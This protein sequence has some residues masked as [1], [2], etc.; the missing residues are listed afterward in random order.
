LYI[1][2]ISQNNILYQKYWFNN[3]ADRMKNCL[4]LHCLLCVCIIFVLPEKC[5]AQA[6]PL[7]FKNFSTRDGLSSASVYNILKDRS[8]F[9]WLATEDGL[10]RFDGTN[11]KVYRHNLASPN[12][13]KV[14]HI[15]ALHEDRKGRLWIGTNGGGLSFYDKATD[16]IYNYIADGISPAGTTVTSI[17][18]DKTGNI[19]VSCFGGLYK[20][21]GNSYQVINSGKDNKLTRAVNGIVVLCMLED[22]HRRKWAGTN[23]GLFCYQPEKDSVIVYRHKDE[24]PT[25]LPGNEVSRLA[26]D[27]MKN[28]WTAGENGVS[29]LLPNGQ[30]FARFNPSSA[31]RRLSSNT[32]FALAADAK[33]RLWIGTQEGL[34]IL[35]IRTNEVTNY[36]PD[37]RNPA[38][39]SSRTIRSFFLDTNGIY[40]IGSF[41]GGLHQYDENYSHFDLKEYNA[42]DPYGLRSPLVT[43]FAEYNNKVFVGTDGGGLQLY[44]PKTGLLDHISLPV[45]VKNEKHD[46]GILALETDFDG[47]LWVGTFSN[48][49]YRYNP[50]TK[51]NVHYKKGPA[52]T[53]LNSA[54]VFCLKQDRNGN[55]W[56]GTNGG[57]I[58]LIRK[59]GAIID[60]YVNDPT[61]PGDPTHLSSNFVRGFEEDSQ[62]NMWVA[63]YG[64]G[65][66]VYDVV[67]KQFIFH[68]KAN[69]GLPSDY[70]MAIKQD[71][72]GNIW[73]GTNGNGMG[74]LKKGSSKFEIISEADGLINGTIHKIIES[75]DG[76]L[77]I[78]TNAGLSSYNPVSKKFKNYTSHNGLQAGAFLPRAGMKMAN[79]D[80][81]FGGQNGFNHF[82]PTK[83][84]TNKNVPPVVFTDLL[85]DNQPVNPSKKSPVSKYILLADEI[86]LGY[87]QSFSISFEA[88]DFT[89]PSDNQYEYQLKGFNTSWVKAGKEHSANYANIPPGEYIFTVRASNNDGV[90]N[91]V[92]KSVKVVVAPPLWRTT[93]AYILYALLIGAALWFMR[94]RGVN[95]IKMQYAL[96]QE[97]KEAKLVIERQ[98]KEAEYLHKLDQIKIKF[99]T[100]LSH[101]F[102]TPIS[103]IMGPV[104]T[105]MGF[106]KDEALLNHLNLIKRNSR[107]LLNL[108][109]QLLDFR[110]MEEKELRLQCTE[111]DIILFTREICD[112]FNDFSRRKKIEFGFYADQQSLPLLFDHD[113]LE[114][115]LFN[116]LSNAFKFTPESGNIAVTLNHS[117]DADNP[118]VTN[119]S[120]SIKDSG[121]GIPK[122]AQARIFESFFQHE[123]GLEVLN[124]GTGI[125]LSITKEFV[126]LH[127]GT[128]GV[129]SQEG[130][131]STFTVVL[132]LKQVPVA[133][134]PN[135]AEPVWSDE[136]VQENPSPNTSNLP[137]AVLIVEDDDD[138]RF[139]LKENLKNTYRIFEAPNGK[140][141]WQRALFHH[142]DIIVCD[143]QMPIM[144][145]MELV[146]KLKADKRTKHIPLVL[147]TA[148]NTTNGVLDGLESGAIDY[149]TKP[150]NFAVLLAK[151]NNILLLNKAYK[152][153]YSR[154]VTVG[155]PDT[156]IVSEKEKFLQKA[157]AYIYANIDNQQLSVEVLSDHMNISRASLYNRLLEYTGLSPVEFIRTVKLEK[158]KELLEKSGMTIMEIAYATGFANP[159]YFSKVFRTKYNITP[160][161]YQTEMT[162]K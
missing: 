114:R 73:V 143:V 93:Y 30:G 140:E 13:L 29:K 79:G 157:L 84:T 22:S 53:D 145:G 126:Q 138:F 132:P 3:L 90:W 146:Q 110:K 77:W 139:Y 72:H 2:G 76:S 21:D 160:T 45:I 83:F 17:A 54:D 47:Q 33:S 81:Y 89:S 156:G 115:I 43:A 105:L 119:V 24:D 12:G 159:N 39:L 55:I 82:S 122:E 162:K 69:S 111:G 86:R 52:S 61:K 32:I 48:G 85:V 106:I 141:G 99:L 28:V 127:G 41:R 124:H 149:M 130:I 16:S 80:L 34:D 154:Q 98:R 107:R 35:D 4:L 31:I 112:S 109:N 18:G 66:S 19:F 147:L 113:K 108:V 67:S 1:S 50:F 121:I 88:L 94:M 101:E 142:P 131:G 116:I 161:E 75:E 56:A 129:E 103:L 65:I 7:N 151:I 123:A 128:I 91:T 37:K 46:M 148:A 49:I 78:S 38:S 68:K 70:V 14:N 74:L 8:G 96:Q 133:P 64:G 15:T 9:L 104:D 20:I 117:A 63:T 57:G 137:P 27:S 120:I 36:I 60:K 40:W 150:F 62:G 135:I 71:R 95:K 155:M 97:R 23:V 6:A 11:F 25:S 158:A 26:E 87:R 58:N 118:T 136:P 51:T 102:K 134:Q 152:D 59:D 44:D 10:N 92:G 5:T 144:N 125:G 153:T 42:F 100:N